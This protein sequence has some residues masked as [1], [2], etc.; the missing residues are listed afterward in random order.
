MGVAAEFR[1][2][3]SLPPVELPVKMLRRDGKTQSRT[4]LNPETVEEYAELM[5]GDIEL[6]PLCAYT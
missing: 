4:S 2:E 6:P 3:G 1:L 5:R